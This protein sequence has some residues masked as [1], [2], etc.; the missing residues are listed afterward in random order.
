MKSQG[1]CRFRVLASA[2]ALS[3]AASAGD[4]RVQEW[5]APANR[6]RLAV[7]WAELAV[8]SGTKPLVPAV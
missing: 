3:A 4:R 6:A 1:K 7:E 8:V 5:R 2:L